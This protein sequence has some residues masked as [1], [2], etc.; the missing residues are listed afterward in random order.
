[1]VRVN[2]HVSVEMEVEVT[3]RRLKNRRAFSFTICLRR[4]N[5]LDAVPECAVVL[6]ELAEPDDPQYIERLMTFA[7]ACRAR[8]VFLMCPS[9]MLRSGECSHSTASR[10]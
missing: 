3:W 1:M 6:A 10:L 9:T 8:F 5:S 7:R 2:L 4:F